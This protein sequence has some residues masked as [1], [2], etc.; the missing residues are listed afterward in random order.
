M[1][2]IVKNR[3]IIV[4]IEFSFLDMSLIWFIQEFASWWSL[5]EKET[6]LNVGKFS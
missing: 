4:S 1:H 3:G 6:C 5:H 2:Y